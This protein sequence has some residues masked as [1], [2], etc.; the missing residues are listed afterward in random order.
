MKISFRLLGIIILYVVLLLSIIYWGV[1]NMHHPFTYHMDE[2]HQLMAV[3]G[4]FSQGSPNIPGAAHGPIFQFLLSGIFLGP[5]YLLGIIDPFAIKSSLGNLEAQKMVFVVLRLNS[6]LF[7]VLSIV[8]LWH[9]A[10]RYVK[11]NPFFTVYFFTITPIWIMLSNYFKYD[12]ALIFWLLLTMYCLLWYNETQNKKLYFLSG[13]LTAL[14]LATKISALP[15]VLIYFLAYFLFTRKNLWKIKDVIV[16]I[17]VF[18]VTFFVFGIPDFFTGTGDYYEYFYSNL[19]VTPKTTDNVLYGISPYLYLPITIFPFLFGHAFYFGIV[20]AGIYALKVLIRKKSDVL[21]KKNR[22]TLFLFISLFLFALSLVPL[23]VSATGNRSLVL[24]PFF[25][26]FLAMF[27]DSLI[28]KTKGYAKKALLLLIGCFMLFQMGEVV[29]WTSIKWLPDPRSVSSEFIHKEVKP[30]EIG[31][32][33]IPIY[34]FLPDI[35][36]KEFYTLADNPKAATVYT[37]RVIDEKTKTL[38][39][40][41]ILTH[42]V[43]ESTYYKDTP[44]KRLLARMKQEGFREVKTFDLPN[45]YYGYF[46]TERELYHAGLV[47]L[48]RI[49]LFMK[50]P[51]N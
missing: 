38:P 13:F 5:F 6:L 19:I 30:T 34:Q 23:K 17:I 35:V 50:S 33:N 39:S 27:M 21:H 3:R 16:S 20:G 11:T 9:I 31:I 14:T 41:I 29:I 12:I 49:S 4:L 42:V 47:P 1:P 28:H 36:L 15:L 24:L 37:Y 44:K 40:T 7:G 26:I 46:K 8:V 22:V 2:W 51:K 45:N 32:E 25:A 48:A 18:F 43:L 10:K